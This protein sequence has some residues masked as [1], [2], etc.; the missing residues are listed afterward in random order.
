MAAHNVCPGTN[1]IVYIYMLLEGTV[2]CS[3]ANADFV[4]F[5]SCMDYFEYATGV[6]WTKNSRKNGETDRA[7]QK[8]HPF[9]DVTGDGSKV[10][11]SKEQYCVGIWN[12]RFMNQGKFEVFK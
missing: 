8:Q 4:I 10:R 11:C 3:K 1:V 9:V 2:K 5:V 7:K 6:Q 12:V